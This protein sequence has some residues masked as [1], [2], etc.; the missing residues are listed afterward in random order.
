M[1]SFSI[2]NR[3]VLMFP[4][5]KADESIDMNLEYQQKHLWFEFSSSN[6][7]PGSSVTFPHLTL[8]ISCQCKFDLTYIRQGYQLIMFISEAIENLARNNRK[9]HSF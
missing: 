7:T 3:A 8:I 9:W 2:A 6:R 5:K 4:Q 1:A